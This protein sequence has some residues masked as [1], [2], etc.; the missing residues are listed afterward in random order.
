MSWSIIRPS[1]P[2][3]SQQFNDDTLDDYYHPFC[4]PDVNVEETNEGFEEETKRPRLELIVD[5]H[6]LAR[7]GLGKA[8]RVLMGKRISSHVICKWRFIILLTETQS[9]AS[10]DS[11]LLDTSPPASFNSST[12]KEGSRDEQLAGTKL[13]KYQ[14]S[15]SLFSGFG[16]LDESNDSESIDMLT[17]NDSESI[18]MSTSFAYYDDFT[19]FDPNASS[20][21]FG[22]KS[23]TQN[24]LA[25]VSN[26]TSNIP[27][28]KR[29]RSTTS[30][31][32]DKENQP[33]RKKRCEKR[34][35]KVK[36]RK[37]IRFDILTVVISALRI[38]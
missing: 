16:Y 5:P 15:G 31:T 26:S 19:S 12:V 11:L 24:P 9:Y 10:E 1:A 38:L 35:E 18:E 3:E 34:P 2:P 23:Q 32:I 28:M 33:Q 20:T 37:F 13:G 29:K 4:F 6:R 7:L 8:R 25:S 30:F 17:S 14:S 36:A 21:P 27:K 22:A